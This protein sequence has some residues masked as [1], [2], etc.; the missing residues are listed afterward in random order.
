MHQPGEVKL[1][2][3]AGPFRPQSRGRHLIDRIGPARNGQTSAAIQ[4]IASQS[5][6]Q[7]SQPA[8]RPQ[9][10][11]QQQHRIAALPLAG[12]AN[13][14][15]PLAESVADSEAND[16]ASSPASATR[17]TRSQPAAVRDSKRGIRTS[18]AEGRGNNTRRE[19]HRPFD[20]PS[21]HTHLRGMAGRIASTAANMKAVRIDRAKPRLHTYTQVQPL[22]TRSVMTAPKRSC[23]R[24]MPA[25]AAAASSHTESLLSFR[26]LLPQGVPIAK[27]HQSAIPYHHVFTISNASTGPH[28]GVLFRVD[29][30]VHGHPV[31]CL[32]DCGATSDF[33][34]LDFL[35]RH[36]LEKHML[37]TEQLVRGYDGQVTP[38]AGVIETPVALALL[39]GAGRGAPQRLLVAQ[40]HSDDVILGLPW[41]SAT[42]A[43]IDFTQR[44]VT[45][46]HGDGRR[47][48]SLALASSPA[49]SSG[50]SP[51]ASARLMEAIMSLYSA[52]VDAGT[53]TVGSS[54][55]AAVM[56]DVDDR[57]SARPR[58]KPRSAEDAALDALRKRVL[59]EHN[60]VFPE[61]LPPG[62]PP[63]RG[64]ELR[65]QLR[66]DSRPPHRQPPRRNQKH[67]AFEAKWIK[68]MLANGHIVQSQSEYAAPHF[69]VDKPDSATTGEFRAVTDY[70]L[71]NEQTVK[72]RY[73]LPR[74]DQLFDKLAHA[75]YFSK[76]DLR[77]GF[78]QILIAAEDRHKTAFV[79]SQGLFEYNVLP[80]GLCNSP[81]VFMSLM[82]DT[83]RDYLDK[84]VLVFLDDIIIYSDTLEDHERHLRLALQ[85]LREQRLCAKLSKSALCHTEV[86]FLGHHVGRAGLRVMEDKIEAVRDWPVPTTLRELR[87]FLG[88]AGYYRRFVRGFSEI[89]LPLTELTRNVT[90]QRLLWST[91]QQLAFIELKRALQ[92]T[93]VLVLPDP[94]LPFVVNC[95]ASGYAVGAVLQQDRGAGLQPIAFMSKKL[96]GAESRYPVHEQELLAIITALTTWRHY[97]S[98][99]ALPVRVR[100]DHKS[101]IHFQTQPMLSGRQTRWLETLA[102]YDYVVE[103]V[104]GDENGAA[105]ALSRRGDLDGGAAERPPAFVD[106]GRTF[107]LNHIMLHTKRTA[108]IDE[109][110]AIQRAE[111]HAPRNQP[112]RQAEIQRQLARAK[113]VD[114]AKRVIPSEEVPAD[115]PKPNANGV[116]V[117]PTQ[118]CTADNKQRAQCGCKT[119]KGQ[120]CHV[121]M[122][123]LDGLRVTKSTV[124]QAGSGLFAARDF[125][126]GAHL[127]DYTGDELI[128]RR[129]GDGGS[130]CLALSQRRA[131][132]AAPTNTGYGRWA[133][134]PRGSNGGPNAEFVLNPARGTGRLRSTARIRKGDEIFVSYGRKYWA[135]F[136]Q[137]AKVVARPAPHARA[138]REVIDLT[139]VAASVFSSELAAEFDTACVGDAAYAARVAKGDRPVTDDGKSD[140]DEL[141]TRDGRL[142][143]RNNGALYV[144]RSES[145][146]TRLIRECHDAAT[147][148]HL[149]RDKTIEQMQRRFF[150]H[151]MTTSVSEYVTTCDACQRNKPSQRR[152]M[153]LLMPIASPTQAAHTWT[154]DLI[155]QMTKSRSGNDAIVVWVCKFSKLRHYAA[156]KTAISAPELARLFLATVVR[157][158]GM[159]ECIISD[160]DPRFT[161]HFWRAFW[162]SLGSTLAMSTAYHPESDGQTENANK[163]L[164]IMLRSV[165]DFSQTDWDEHLPAAELAYNNS[166]NETTGYSPFYLVYGREARMPL[167]LA[168]APLT[169]AADNPT[170]AEA[171]ARWRAALQQASINTSSQQQRQKKYADRTR[172]EKQ[173]AIGDRVLLSTQHLKLV[174]ERKRSRKFTERFVGP[175]R[176]KRVVNAN[177]YELELPA[178][179]KIHPVINISHL[180]EYRD[181]AQAFPDRPIRITRPEPE[182]LDD[183]GAP[184][185]RV[186]RLL[187]HRTVKRGKRQTDQYLVEWKG[188]PIS[189]ATWE[190]IENL[191]GSFE[192]VTEFNEK[193]RIQLS[194]VE[195]RLARTFSQ[196]ARSPTRAA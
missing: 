83:F 38:A 113:A 69:Y 48:I 57:G 109:I 34:S 62:L 183:N 68:E 162:T 67:A 26:S 60:D 18:G 72:N 130:Y 58:A 7:R 10:Q 135:T 158:H 151:G 146:R 90:H 54:D 147:A 6:S 166:K 27:S 91:R 45:L 44:L 98:G 76:I 79:T 184:E 165:I 31:R 145:L 115:R 73:P 64:H 96:S 104:R 51:T 181:G 148:G 173:F 142:F 16:I 100:T 191:T 121:H 172:R 123:A 20:R 171:T 137:N 136:G 71:L 63:G 155:T 30:T 114:A 150:W 163:T 4:P 15:A 82:N 28:G 39:D 117:M 103:Y 97:L 140:P 149:G 9:Q 21:S 102:D 66:P 42:G 170:A 5:Q 22:N 94:K 55:L 108:L 139:T 122:R 37:A 152:T 144:P 196:V 56:R 118:R 87:A 161:A 84:F 156:C 53:H 195:T 13:P 88:L 106:T 194:A 125:A 179:L 132:D 52:E 36:G 193:R 160:R 59:A 185:W 168:L 126:P 190:P 131:I 33:V 116:I 35:R 143:T 153:G 50:S 93:P 175:Y 40:L 189:E 157:H 105:D 61:K 107:E 110:N 3:P 174:G 78:Y 47:T 124:A 127:A 167:D 178:S 169:K 19:P 12:N 49:Q 75:K 180:K 141:V 74:A 129:D 154:M 23:M 176:V 138:A 164:E 182:A 8:S 46:D 177:A 11:Q 95:D 70:R 24:V 120:H 80:M 43:V 85:R 128:I 186:D 86:E 25:V 159:P 112:D 101:L 188:Y 134:D 119:A 29:A 32:I 1:G 14:F 192:L 81:G 89:A 17:A 99:T 41:L 187:D 2:G 133:N 65:I 92:A 77:T 111:R